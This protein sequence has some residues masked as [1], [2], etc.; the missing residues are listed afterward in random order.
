MKNRTV[1]LLILIIFLFAG[2]GT[3]QTDLN[4]ANIQEESSI[5]SENEEATA[6]LDDEETEV[7]ITDSEQDESIALEAEEFGTKVFDTED[8]KAI[9]FGMLQ[10]E[11]CIY[12][13]KEETKEKGIATFY[14]ELDSDCFSLKNDEIQEK[15]TI[16]VQNCT[17]P[18]F[19][20]FD[21]VKQ[22]FAEYIA[23]DTIEI[24]SNMEEVTDIEALYVAK[25]DGL[26]YYLVLYSEASY[27]IRTEDTTMAYDLIGTLLYRDYLE[28]TFSTETIECA[29]GN[30][31]QLVTDI[32]YLTME[33]RYELHMEGEEKEDFS[34]K[35][36]IT[37]GVSYP[38]HN[39]MLLCD[40]DGIQRQSLEWEAYQIP[41]Y[42]Q[43]VDLN[44]DGYVDIKVA[45]DDAP[46]YHI[47]D[48]YLWN[49]AE[50]NFEKVVYDDVLAYVEVSD[51]YLE[52]W[53]RSGEGYVYQILEWDGN[54]LLLKSEELILPDEE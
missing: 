35:Y 50:Q 3:K 13:I 10:F 54:K 2:C 45:W 39:T 29:G 8:Y 36:A 14:C 52:N 37:K 41:E 18:N 25:G 1:Y 38:Y 15:I 26:A 43:F 21:D 6:A 34:L 47:Y 5:V 4:K 19:V 51:G 42:P 31:V 33:A 24:Y 17:L 40:A 53:I 27:I 7:L 16:S 30:Q 11:N 20:V 49:P 28:K 46:A 44:R 12:H 22:F 48:F 9:S 32:S 23:Y